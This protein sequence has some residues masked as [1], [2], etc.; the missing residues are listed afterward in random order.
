MKQPHRDNGLARK[1]VGSPAVVIV[2]RLILEP[3][4]L[5][6]ALWLSQFWTE[7]KI[8]PAPP[9]P[10]WE[11]SRVSSQRKVSLS[12]HL[13]VCALPCTGVNF[14]DWWINLHCAAHYD[15]DCPFTAF[16]LL[17]PVHIFQYEWVS[18]CIY[19]YWSQQKNEAPAWLEVILITLLV[20]SNGEISQVA[21]LALLIR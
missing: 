15:Y 1:T 4:S 2:Y 7:I 5:R 10:K 13:N 9:C 20:I 18:V 19:M 17:H 12:F 14:T 16:S 6:T 21:M 11:R 3:R 8:E